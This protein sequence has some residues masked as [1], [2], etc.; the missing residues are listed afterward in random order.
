MAI[1]YYYRVVLK[2]LV[3][4]SIVFLIF[5]AAAAALFATKFKTV[6]SRAQFLQAHPAATKILPL[7]WSIRKLSDIAY[8]PYAFRQDET[9]AY[10]LKISEPDLAKMNDSLPKGFMN[11]IYADD[12]RVAVPAIFEAEGKSYQVKVRYRG[13]NAVHWNAPKRSY[14]IKF[15]KDQLFRGMRELNFIIPDDR[16][17]A[18]EHFNSYRAQKLG[19]LAPQTGFANLQVNNLKTALYFT[20][21]GWS[22]E[23]LSKWGLPEDADIY[24]NGYS[25]DWTSIYD[26]KLLVSDGEDSSK[27]AGL[28]GFLNEAGDE[29]FYAKIFDLVDQDNF[30]AWQIHQELANSSHQHLD[31]HRLYFDP[32]AGKFFFIPWDVEMELL[33]RNNFGSYG[34]LAERIFANPVFAREKNE[35]LYQYVAD[36]K[37]LED[38]LRFYDQTYGSFRISLYR[39]R[40]KIYTNR[41]ADQAHARHRQEI[42]DIFHY[43]RGNL[44]I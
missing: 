15:D 22:A 32:S 39:D 10:T 42:I 6:Y 43:L 13:E 41:F 4:F 16:L 37:N 8:L 34:V 28:I 38:D 27:L 36:E 30:Y 3:F 40:L 44:E 21:E 18:V 25:S 5:A 20:V 9:P 12:D 23:M 26:W 33:K 24:G 2:L 19:L 29:E 31:N 14:F 1:N 11:V 17:F 7:Y 35:R